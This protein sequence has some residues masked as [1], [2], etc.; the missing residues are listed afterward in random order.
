MKRPFEKAAAILA[1]GA[2]LAE[3][4]LR[5]RLKER[6]QTDPV[7]QT[8]AVYGEHSAFAWGGNFSLIK[9]VLKLLS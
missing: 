7:E 6:L 1:L 9:A 3:F 8:T 5:R 2:V 4:L